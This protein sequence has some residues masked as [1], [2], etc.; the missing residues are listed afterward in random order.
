MSLKLEPKLYNIYFFGDEKI[1]ANKEKK[2]FT[3][4][5]EIHGEK[6]KLNLLENSDI[7]IVSNEEKKLNGIL[8]FYNVNDI[9]SFNKLKETIEKIIDMNKYEMPLIVVGNNYNNE[10]RKITYDE[11]KNFLDKYGIKYHEIES[12]ENNNINF[13]NIFND[14]GEQVLY[15]EIIEKD[16]NIKLNENKIETENINEN[17][18]NINKLDKS[19]ENTIEKNKEINKKEEKEKEKEIKN[20]KVK[21][22]S[23]INKP[24]KPKMKTESNDVKEKKTTAQI[25]REELVR[26]KRLKREKEMQQWYKK[27]EYEGI[28]LKKK[29]EKETKLKLFEKLKEDKEIQKKKE[30][31]VQEE[32]SSQKKERYEK[33]KKEREE[34]GKKFI[35]EKEKNK[36]QLEQKLKSEKANIKKLLSQNV[37]LEKKSIEQKRSKILSPNS[38]FRKSK[39]NLDF[40]LSNNSAIL[41]NTISD[42][43]INEEST[44]TKKIKNIKRINTGNFQTLKKN[45]TSINFFKK[46]YTKENKLKKD[47]NNNAKEK[48]I[49]IEEINNIINMK[50]ELEKEKNI[51]E[52]LEQNYLNNTNN[53]YRCFYCSRIPIININENEHDININCCF[54]N[55][56]YNNIYNY[57]FF[58]QKSLDHPISEENI[59][60]SFC[61]KKINEIKEQ[62]P[63]SELKYCDKCN[64]FICT[65]DDLSHKNYHDIINHKELKEQYKKIFSN[66]NI[67]NKNKSLRRRKTAMGNELSKA[68]NSAKELKTKKRTATPKQNKK[69]EDKKKLKLNKTEIKKDDIIDKNN[70]DKIPLYMKDSCCIEHNKIYKY[71]CS[72]CNKN[73]CSIC[74]EKHLEHNLINLSDIEINEKDLL[75]IKQLFEKEITNLKKINDYFLALIEKIKKEFADIYELKM[76]E[77]EIK[78]KII[79]N[80]EI[81]KYNYNSIKNVQNIINQNKNNFSFDYDCNDNNKN[82]ALKEINSIFNLLKNNNK[83]FHKNEIELKN[84]DILNI[85][86]MIKLNT[87]DI[88]ISSFDGN[89]SIYNNQTYELLLNKKIFEEN[90]GINCMIQLKNGD[91]ILGRKKLKIINLNL[92]NKKCEI[93]NEINLK[94]G[95]FDSIIEMGNKF[96]ITYD[97]NNELKLWKNYK[98]IYKFKTNISNLFKIDDNSFITSSIIENKI[99]IYKINFNKSIPELIKFSLNKEMHIKEGKNSLIKIDNSC[100]IIIY[101]KDNQSNS[102]DNFE[103]SKNNE[104]DKEQGICLIEINPRKKYFKILDKIQNL[105]NNK[106]YNNLV[107]YLNDQFMVLEDYSKYVEI[108]GWNSIIKKIFVK[109]RINF[110]ANDEIIINAIFIEGIN[111]FIFQTNKNLICLSDN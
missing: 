73:I 107:I 84:N 108:W 37:L 48:D 16:N 7:S 36:I 4:E 46:K 43:N 66:K 60:C 11:A 40:D 18:E 99:S 38:S 68:V 92:E 59:S 41:N 27:K 56:N 106:N 52:R 10:E 35:S 26:E 95:L 51:K 65:E 64:N 91:I 3:K 17:S 25:K 31:E 47:N 71:Y 101:E 86:S 105:Y 93:I 45:S 63:K 87:N 72:N 76:K 78:Q 14:L 20:N 6:I 80:Y 32:Y 24:F 98:F 8:L 70:E 103:E 55:T 2:D 54:N 23:L 109:N 49:N 9:N 57:D 28:E 88:A 15:Q 77:I 30:K 29:K 13:E 12:G 44:K 34:E 79:E 111:D 94:D 74:N 62:N 102:E 83:I 61:N 100:F 5:I 82:D 22:A 96:L 21:K 89:L 1:L 58:I 104:E 42:F 110:F 97:T 85:S 67:I 81:I 33:S 53:I 75:N 19:S 39:K 90:E 69:E 50:I